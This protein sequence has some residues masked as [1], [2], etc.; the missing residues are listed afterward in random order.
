MGM[1]KATAVLIGIIGGMLFPRASSCM[2]NIVSDIYGDYMNIAADTYLAAG[3][4]VDVESMHITS[5]VRLEN[6]AEIQADIYV[7]DNCDFHIKNSGQISGNIHLGSGA[8]MVQII[9]D[10]EDITYLNVNGPYV[11]LADGVSAI[12]WD[13]LSLL[14]AN[15]G[16]L[17]LRNS[18]IV[19]GD[20]V[21]RLAAFRGDVSRVVLNGVITLNI[22]EDY[23][24]SDSPLMRNVAGDATVV[25]SGTAPGPLHAF[26]ADIRDGDLY[27]KLVR[28]TDYYKIL[29]NDTGRMLN[30]VRDI[31]PDDK[32]LGRLDM[33]QTMDELNHIMKSS[34]ALNPIRLASSA[35]ILDGFLINGIKFDTSG[36][37]GL[38]TLGARPIYIYSDDISIYAL[39]A[40]F[41]LTPVKGLNV[42][43]SGYGARATS[44]DEINNFS[45][46]MYG[47]NFGV[48]Y[49]GSYLRS[50]FV[51][52]ATYSEFLVP[53]I[54]DGNSIKDEAKGLCLY[55]VA[56]FGILL[57]GIEPYVGI[58]YRRDKILDVIETQVLSR[59][60][61]EA[62]FIS[63]GVDL[64]Y[65]Y[66]INAAI[67]SANEIHIG[68]GAG[69][70]SDD[71]MAGGDITVGVA[72][73]DNG[74]SYMF[75]ISAKIKF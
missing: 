35:R 6:A 3:V 9:R 39:S 36:D 43:V 10:R 1:R 47:A 51:L 46:D 20:S 54:F 74:A 44:D 59:T 64:E 61:F 62:E 34:I 73:D 30:I 17:V 24:Y 55:G 32:L 27:V 18:E 37:A 13:E 28:E 68:A 19:F 40:D 4:I 56:D 48:K 57:G 21:P 67:N 60:G 50:R 69:F 29:G 63:D 12:S 49:S 11:V 5:S 2:Q 23:L 72:H 26:N 58:E 41:S 53:Y 45:A 22:S 38:V 16:T 70:W 14:G 65:R 75:S 15:A 71:D 25:F 52:G 33:A 31:W 42:G 7:C 66:K 8:E